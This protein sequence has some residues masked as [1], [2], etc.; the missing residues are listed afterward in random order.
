MYWIAGYLN[1]TFQ[2]IKIVLKIIKAGI[3]SDFRRT[4]H[5]SIYR[6][7][8]VNWRTQVDKLCRYWRSYRQF[9]TKLANF[10][11]RTI[12]DQPTEKRSYLMQCVLSRILSNLLLPLTILLR[13]HSSE[14]F[15]DVAHFSD[16]P[17]YCQIYTVVNSIA[18]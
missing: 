2:C 18:Q 15:Y 6:P 14:K 3:Y 10:N 9:K 5:G 1:Y 13:K 16:W 12:Y 7:C 8:R 4:A 11:Y 17:H